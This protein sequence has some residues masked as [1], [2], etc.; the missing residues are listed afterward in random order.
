MEILYTLGGLRLGY[1]I[2]GG[3]ETL[4]PDTQLAVVE[5]HINAKM[6]KYLLLPRDKDEKAINISLYYKIH[7]NLRRY[8]VG[9]QL[10]VTE[11]SKIGLVPADTTAGDEV[12][13]FEKLPFHVS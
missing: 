2:L 10:S 9:R 3:C 13:G 1:A 11:D 6:A 4:L 7:S 5:S 8:G 12:V